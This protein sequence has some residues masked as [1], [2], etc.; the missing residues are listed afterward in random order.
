MQ[1]Q[2]ALQDYFSRVSGM[3]PELFNIA[4]AV[5]GSAERAEYALESALLEGWTDGTRRGAGFREGMKGLVTRIAL[6]EIGSDLDGAVWEGLPRTDSE[7]L[8]PLLG[9]SAY[10]QRVAALRF[11]CELQP[12]TIARA[13][14]TTRAQVAESL[15]RIRHLAGRG[16]PQMI[17]AIRRAMQQSGPGMP[18]AESLYRALRAEAMEVK[19]PTHWFRRAVGYVVVA[20]LVLLA[21]CLFW[22][23]AVLIQPETIE[24]ADDAGNVAVVV[25]E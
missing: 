16:E 6:S 24:L 3:L 4:Y 11:G 5:T 13:T 12:R 15:A 22:L 23:T 19:P 14:G 2:D 9:E 25:E 17:R 1:N 10:T 7:A 20:A 8:S 21:A 18:P